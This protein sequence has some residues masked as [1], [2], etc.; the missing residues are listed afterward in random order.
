MIVRAWLP[1]SLVVVL[2]LATTSPATLS[3]ILPSHRHGIALPVASGDKTVADPSDSAWV[4]LRSAGAKGDGVAD[5]TAAIQAALTTAANAD[6]P[7][8]CRSGTYLVS[9]SLTLRTDFVGFSSVGRAACVIKYTGT[10]PALIVHANPVRIQNVVVDLSQDANTG[11]G[12]I[13]LPDVC[14]QCA[15]SSITVKGPANGTIPYL[16]Y[17]VMLR[18]GGTQNRLTNITTEFATSAIIAGLGSNNF[19]QSSLNN[20]FAHNCGQMTGRAC[21]QITGAVDTIMN[22]G[23]GGGDFPGA[24]T[25]TA[26]LISGSDAEA[27]DIIASELFANAPDGTAIAIRRPAHDVNVVTLIDVRLPV[28]ARLV[29]DV[30]TPPRLTRIATQESGAGPVGFFGM[31]APVARFAPAPDSG[32]TLDACTCTAVAGIV[33]FKTGPVRP[34]SGDLFAT[35]EFRRVYPAAPIVILSPNSA[36]A[37]NIYVGSTSPRSATLGSADLRANTRY[38]LSYQVIE[39]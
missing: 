9:S 2:V 38:V 11:T 22:S 31:A 34:R 4:F 5:D 23:I 26:V 8:F 14:I 6:R 33:A 35:I 32:I 13:L 39:R 27:I 25:R 30:V 16:N 10:G 24:R 12:G 36:S 28:P 17:G 1:I 7:V 15:L 18:G 3:G 20:V 37:V 29:S 21:L 19:Y